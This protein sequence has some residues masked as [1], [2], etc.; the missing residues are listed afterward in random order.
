MNTGSTGSCTYPRM[1]N[2][3]GF[4]NGVSYLP[5]HRMVIGDSEGT[6]IYER[7]RVRD[8]ERGGRGSVM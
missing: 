3:R 4:N 6:M 8:D 1:F 5:V 2:D 7:V